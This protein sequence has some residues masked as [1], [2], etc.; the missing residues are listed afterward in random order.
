MYI[1]SDIAT[2]LLQAPL[3]P[4]GNYMFEKCWYNKMTC[5]LHQR[6]PKLLNICSV[7]I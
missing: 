1:N 3:Y 4:A 2:L 5:S 6:K 7:N